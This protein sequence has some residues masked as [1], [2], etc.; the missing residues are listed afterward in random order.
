MKAIMN[1]SNPFSSGVLVRTTLLVALLPAPTA[2][3]TCMADAG[4]TPQHIPVAPA[5]ARR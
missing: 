4:C 3:A 5:P 1:L 2:F